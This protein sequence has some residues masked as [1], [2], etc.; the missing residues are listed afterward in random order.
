LHVVGFSQLTLKYCQAS[1]SRPAV[2]QQL[3]SSRRT[4]LPPHPPILGGRSAPKQRYAAESGTMSRQMTAG[5]SIDVVVAAACLF[6]V[7]LA[8]SLNLLI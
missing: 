8:L 3:S 6:V 1:A 2:Q 5:G 7:V 4:E